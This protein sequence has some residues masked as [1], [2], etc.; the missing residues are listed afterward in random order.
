MQ[1]VFLAFLT[2][3]SAGFIAGMYVD[4]E[5]KR[6]VKDVISDRVKQM[7]DGCRHCGEAKEKAPAEYVV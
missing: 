4:D 5:R 3:M 1:R 6:K 7:Y 2:G